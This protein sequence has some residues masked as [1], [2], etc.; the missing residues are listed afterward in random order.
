MDTVFS[1]PTERSAWRLHRNITV[2][3][4]GLFVHPQKAFLGA[5]PDALVQCSCCGEGL[6]EIKCPRT[7]A[8]EKPTDSNTNCLHKAESGKPELKKN[9]SVLLSGIQ[10]Q[11]GV[12]GRTWCD[13]YV[14]SKAGYHLERVLFDES[15][16]QKGVAAAT[17]FF[18]EHVA[19]ELVHRRIKNN[20]NKV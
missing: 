6:L 9:P 4:C 8:M 14:F 7:A 20:N 12:T 17:Q 13:F 11:M 19:P 5:T 3:E 10:A 1:H 18:T 15:V 16:W 2:T